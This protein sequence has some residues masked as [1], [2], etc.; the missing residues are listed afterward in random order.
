LTVEDF[1]GVLGEKLSAKVGELIRSAEFRY[2]EVTEAERDG[3][4]LEIMKRLFDD[5]LMK[6]GPHR[7]QQWESGWGENLDALKKKEGNALA[8]RY[9]GKFDALRWRQRFIKPLAKNF[10][11]QTLRVIQAWLSEKYF[12]KSATIYEFGCGTGHHLLDVHRTNGRAALHGLDW[13]TSSQKIISQIAE[14]DP[15]INITGHRFD[16]FNPDYSI[17]LAPGN[18]VYTVAALE[19]IGSGFRPFVE[20]LLEN[21]PDICV[22]TEPIGELLDQNNLLDYLSVKYFEKRNYLSGFLDHLRALESAGKI[23]I[24]EARRTYTGSLFI[25]GY[26]VVAWSPL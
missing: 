7:L 12:S 6:A 17:K 15:S 19:Q 26:S 14:K 23:K 22:H 3:Y 8:P 5:T 1:E 2:R 10:E 21:K 11:G 25:E 9:F 18:A 20:Y 16:F 13:A 24:H 4:L